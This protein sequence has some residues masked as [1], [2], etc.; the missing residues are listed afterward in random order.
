M[1]SIFKICTK[2]LKYNVTKYRFCWFVITN[3]NI[4]FVAVNNE[5]FNFKPKSR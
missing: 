5:C 3:F 1:I 2:I 4:I